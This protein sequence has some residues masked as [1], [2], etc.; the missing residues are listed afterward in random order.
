MSFWDEPKLLQYAQ[1]IVALPILHYLAVLK[2]V[3]PDA[4]KLKLPSSRRA[5][6]FRLSL[7]SAAKL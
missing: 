2:A 4:F 7:V 1:I 3:H 5:E 6:L